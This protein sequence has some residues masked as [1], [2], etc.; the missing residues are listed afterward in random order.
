MGRRGGEVLGLLV[1]Q[2]WPG[3]KPGLAAGGMH[4][5]ERPGM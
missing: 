3:A 2:L 5:G 4:E 1:T